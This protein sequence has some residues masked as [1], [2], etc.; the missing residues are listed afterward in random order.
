MSEPATSA[1]LLQQGLIHHRQGQLDLAMARYVEVLRNDPQNPDALYYVAVVACQEE[2]F[3]QGVELARRAIEHGPPQARVHNL[4]GQALYRLGEPLEA[5]KNFDRAIA[6]D[7]N[8]ADAHGN[9]AN[10]LVDSGLPE[11]ALKSF[12][13]AL[14]LNPMS[15]P[16]WLN[17]GALLQELGRH[18]DALVSFD[19][20]IVCGPG[21]AEAHVNR[22]NA[23]KDSGHLDAARALPEGP[24]FEEAAAAYSQA[25]ALE[26]RMDEAYLGRGMLNLVRGDWPAGFADYE[27]REKVGKPTFVAL[28]QPRWDGE[29]RAGER[30]VLVG[31]QGLGDTIQFCRFAP[32][33]AARGFDVTILTRKAMAPLLSSLKGV[34]IATEADQLAQDQRPLRWLPLLS[35]PGALGI[36][37]DSVPAEVP[38][39]AAE[40][41]RIAAWRARLGGAGFKIGINWASGHSD[42]AYFTRRDISLADFAGLVALPGVQLISLQKGAAAAQTGQVAFGEQI[43]TLDADPAADADFF[44]DTAAVMSNLDLIVTCDTSVAHLAGALARPVFTALPVVADWRWLIGR[45]DSPWYPTMRLFRQGADRQWGPALARIVEAVREKMTQ[46]AQR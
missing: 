42:K 43:V 24:R 26:P 13:R 10:I 14:A 36:R 37:P 45:A 20:A 38:Y 12:D 25:I 32:V 3:Q 31:E 18:E 6:L 21:V 30:L 41:A 28:P 16:D 34:T 15:G 35:V 7:G 29:L 2:Q 22:A 33:L 1:L 8:F 4:L 44:L 40:P 23:L 17:R 9:R 5:I 27:H 11:E 39:L 46:A 19:K